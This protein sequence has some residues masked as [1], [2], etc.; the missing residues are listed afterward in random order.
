MTID[1]RWVTPAA[2]GAFALSS[3]TGILLFFHKDVG[4]NKL[5]HEWL[6]WVLLLTVMLHVIVNYG[7]FKKHLGSRGGRIIMLGFIVV[8]ALS[9]IPIGSKREPAYFPTIR[10]LSAAK[11]STIAEL[12]HKSPVE[13]MHILEGQGLHPVSAEQTLEELAGSNTRENTQFLKRVFQ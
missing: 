10:A 2:A 5:A 7:G 1:R 6:S 11:L 3:V 12:A 9:F 4:L 8:L 13:V